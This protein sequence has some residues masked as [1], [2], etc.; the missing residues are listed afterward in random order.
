MDPELNLAR[1]L[2]LRLMITA[3][4]EMFRAGR[5]KAR[6]PIAIDAI[7]EAMEALG[8]GVEAAWQTL[9]QESNAEPADG[10]K[11][12]LKDSFELD[13]LSKALFFR[14]SMHAY[15]VAREELSPVAG[16]NLS[17]V[18]KEFQ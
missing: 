3:D 10:S 11:W 16:A 8:G 12:N 13:T 4:V 7:D 18:P 2:F 15:M 6:N 1:T 14:D 9:V 17:E 5:W